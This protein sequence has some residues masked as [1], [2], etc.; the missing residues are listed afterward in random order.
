MADAAQV[1]DTPLSNRLEWLDA[2]RGIGIVLVVYAHGARALYDVLPNL[3]AFQRIDQIVYAFHMPLFFFLAGLVSTS[4]LSRSRAAFLRGK[5]TT[6]VYPYFVWSI[7]YWALELLFQEYVNSP[8]EPDAI[9]TI[10]WFPIE[11]LWFLYVLFLCQV[12]AALLWPRL[13]ALV[14]LSAWILLGP[15]PPINVPQL[16][17][18]L[19]WFVAGLLMAPI[20]LKR[21]ANAARRAGFS[22]AAAALFALAAAGAFWSGLPARLESFLLAGV[23]ISL[24]IALATG[25]SGSRGLTYLGSASLSIYLLH[26]IFAAGVREFFEAAYPIPPLI[27]LAVTCVAGLLMPLIVH[28]AARRTGLSLY[29]GLGKMASASPQDQ[30]RAIA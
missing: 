12:I 3:A 20:M 14:L 21:E 27:M 28:E 30:R 5:V 22:L 8:V 24:T 15:V 25:L 7:A 13:I 1:R 16:W 6:V 19:P 23:G 18:Q 10:L 9:I 29:L 11:H 26:T 17:V 4:S 2:A